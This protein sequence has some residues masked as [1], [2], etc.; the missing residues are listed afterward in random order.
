MDECKPL[1]AGRGGGP[2]Y[3]KAVQVEPMKPTLKAPGSTC[4]KL[5]YDEPPSEFAFKFNLR[6]YTMAS[7]VDG[8]DEAYD[9]LN[10]TECCTVTVSVADN[11]SPAGAYT[12]SILSST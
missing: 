11:D 2:R 5:K 3:G 12:R 4:L 9:G 1:D 8:L 6:R 7:T 10:T